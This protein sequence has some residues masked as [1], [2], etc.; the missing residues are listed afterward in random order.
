MIDDDSLCGVLCVVGNVIVHHGDDPLSWD[1]MFPHDLVRVT[2]VCLV[3]V[4]VVRVGSGDQDGPDVALKGLN[5]L[6]RVLQLILVYYRTDKA[7]GQ[8]GEQDQL[9]GSGFKTVAGVRVW[10]QTGA[11]ADVSLILVKE[12]SGSPS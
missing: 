11:M 2:H 6:N 8:Q 12:M 5:L 4:V 3:P 10:R 9:H 1:A 7:D